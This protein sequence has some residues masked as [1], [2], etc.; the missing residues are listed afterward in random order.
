MGLQA[1]LVAA[2]AGPA[3]RVDLDVPDVPGAAGRTSVDLA[4]DD[5]AAADAGAY[6]D[7]EEVAHGAGHARVLLPH[8][9]EVHV[10]VDHDGAAQLLAERLADRETVPAGHDRRRDRHALGEADGA[11][12]PDARAVEAL[13]ESG[14]PQFGGQ[15]Q[16]L[17]EDGDG[18]LA[19][20]HRVVEVSQ[21]LQ[22]R[23]GDGHVDRGRADVDPEEPQFGSEPDVV[24]AA[25]AARCG[26]SVGHHQAGLQ[27][28]VHLDGELRA[29]EP[30]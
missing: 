25:P 17:L 10:V 14:G 5:D 20:V 7:A 9:H 2:G 4:A 3:V 18:A 23:V 22:L 21:Y 15:R 28:P 11:G 24:R 12:D 6:L 19:H 8:R 29:R 26:E 1:A 30:T 13:G 16:D 27:Q